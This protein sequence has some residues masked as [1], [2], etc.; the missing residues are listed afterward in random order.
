MTLST[1]SRCVLFL[2]AN[3]CIVYNVVDDSEDGLVLPDGT[4]MTNVFMESGEKLVQC[5][6]ALPTSGSK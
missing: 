3:N 4:V 1:N 2:Q 5:R 6:I